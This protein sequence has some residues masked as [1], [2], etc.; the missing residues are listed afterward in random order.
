[1]NARFSWL[2]H[3]WCVACALAFATP[4]FAA[5]RT[6][7]LQIQIRDERN[8]C[9]T[10]GTTGAKRACDPSGNYSN[11]VGVSFE[12]WDK[13]AT[14]ADDDFIGVWVNAI[15]GVGCVTFD[16]EAS[17]ADDGDTTEANPDVY[18][19]LKQ[20]VWGLDPS[21]PP[22]RVKDAAG[23]EVTTVVT[24]RDQGVPFNLTDCTTGST[25]SFGDI[26]IAT[27]STTSDIAIRLEMLD[28]AQ[29]G[30]ELYDPE[31]GTDPIYA[32]YPVVNNPNGTS[33]ATGLAWTQNDFCLPNGLGD[34]GDRTTHEFGHVAQM[35]TFEQNSLNDV[36]V[37]GAWSMATNSFETE[38]AATTE[39]FAAYVGAVAWY[40]PQNNSVVPFYGGANIEDA[41]LAQATCASNI[42]LPLQAA[43][44]FWD[45]DDLANEAG[46]RAGADND[47]SS[48]ITLW[49]LQRWDNF[50]DGT[51][52]RQD[53]ENDNNG[54]NV[55]DY[56]FQAGAT[57]AETLLEH[58]C[59]VSQD[60]N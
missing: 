40:D 14:A 60:D 6:V 24:W 10:P 31:L 5:N 42:T 38:S 47:T 54:V 46:T 17:R 27:H 21:G 16:W 11:F 45:L 59:L 55:R 29:R 20:E 43:K 37:G 53:R 1:M 7:C 19:R 9:P 49:M 36:I 58:N 52:N 13:D 56:M 34:D 8:G 39:G 22:L 3:T 41:A 33:C 23:T 57:H 25:C 18:L 28:S 35:R 4:S 32:W 51:S 44:T 30:L 26:H 50:A 12:L 2:M 48:Q 15:N